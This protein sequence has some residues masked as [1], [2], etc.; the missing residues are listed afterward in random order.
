MTEYFKRIDA[1]LAQHQMPPEYK[2]T[3][4]F[5]YCNDC[6]QKSYAKFHFVYHKCGG[7]GGY[8][9]KVLHTEETQPSEE[10]EETR[11]MQQLDDIVDSDE[12]EDVLYSFG[13]EE[14]QFVDLPE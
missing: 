10:E 14:E 9:T 7:C 2:N 12:E 1:L 6:E 3:R 11:M 4:S 5:V 8:N 13:E